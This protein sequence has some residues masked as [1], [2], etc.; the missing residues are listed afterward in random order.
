MPHNAP[1]LLYTKEQGFL[2]QYG[3]HRS[4]VKDA[5]AEWSER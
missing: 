3:F 2:S 1:F 5:G 4:Y